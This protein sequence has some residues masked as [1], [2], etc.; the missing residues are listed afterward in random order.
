MRSKIWGVVFGAVALVGVALWADKALPSP[1]EVL[2]ESGVDLT[3]AGLTAAL[4]DSRPLVREMAATLIG[5]RG[6]ESA[7][8][9]LKRNLKDAYMYSRIAAAGALLDIGDGAGEPALVQLATGPDERVALDAAGVLAR[10]G[11]AAGFEA[12]KRIATASAEPLNRL[13]AVRALPV[14]TK[15][16][17]RQSSVVDALASLLLNDGDV[18]V[19]RGAAGELQSFRCEQA[20]QAFSRV[21]RD[22]DP[23]IRGIAEKYLGLSSGK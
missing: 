18:R 15:L 19:R 1:S 5:Q 12:V 11:N 8:P 9:G 22:A 10:H 13:L 6:I 4:S 17:R 23:V 3:P 16:P 14:F 20:D 7:V 21:R 2:V